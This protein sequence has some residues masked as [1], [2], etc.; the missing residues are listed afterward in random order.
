MKIEIQNAEYEIERIETSDGKLGYQT[1][2]DGI[3]TVIFPNIGS[4]DKVL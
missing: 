2:I 1:I 3:D 4:Q